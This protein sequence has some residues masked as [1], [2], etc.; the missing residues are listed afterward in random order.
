[1]NYFKKLLNLNNKKIFI[2][3]GSG[4]IGSQVCEGL[5]ELNGFVLNLDIKNNLK[6]KDNNYSFK[7]FN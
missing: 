5:L 6:I 1:M 4:L 3:G 2:I 7:Y